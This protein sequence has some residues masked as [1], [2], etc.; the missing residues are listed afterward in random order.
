MF[1][2]RMKIKKIKIFNKLIYL[3]LL[4]V[5]KND[6]FNFSKYLNKKIVKKIKSLTKTL[7][8]KLK[9]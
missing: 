2:I 8:T 6:V 3:F 1:I 4:F 7:F 9:K 5:L